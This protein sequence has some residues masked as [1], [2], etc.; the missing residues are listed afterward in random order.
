VRIFGGGNPGAGQTHRAASG[1]RGRPLQRRA[2][3]I[4]THSGAGAA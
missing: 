2:R 1:W 4:G 3:R